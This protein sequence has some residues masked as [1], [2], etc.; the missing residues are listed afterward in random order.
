VPIG[1]EG[2]GVPGEEMLLNS[3]DEVPEQAVSKAN[4]PATTARL[5]NVRRLG[6]ARRHSNWACEAGT[7]DDIP[8]TADANAMPVHVGKRA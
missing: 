3:S 8:S 1:A 7:M 5:R 2:G 6:C 4:R